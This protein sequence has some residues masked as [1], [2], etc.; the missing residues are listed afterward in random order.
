[1]RRCMPHCNAGHLDQAGMAL[2]PGQFDAKQRNWPFMILETN[3]SSP[4]AFADLFQACQQS[5]MLYAVCMIWHPCSVGSNGHLLF[6]S[7]ERQRIPAVGN[8]D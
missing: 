5:F 2:N 6:Q 4:V 7:Q 3:G 1:M 8:T